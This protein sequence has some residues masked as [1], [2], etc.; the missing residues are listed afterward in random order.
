ML[1][2]RHSQ[3]KYEQRY[4]DGQNPITERLDK[5]RGLR[6]AQYGELEA[7]LSSLIGSR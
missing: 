2:R 6:P 7:S 4:G 3:V 1:S 5:R